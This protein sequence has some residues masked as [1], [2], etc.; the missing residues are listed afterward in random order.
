VVE[1]EAQMIVT[2]TQREDGKWTVNLIPDTEREEYDFMGPFTC[3]SVEVGMEGQRAIR[4]DKPTVKS[5][6]VT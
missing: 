6:Y 1:I 2:I 5:S 4:S 3:D